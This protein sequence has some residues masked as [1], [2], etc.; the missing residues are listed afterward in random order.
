MNIIFVNFELCVN[1]EG[2]KIAQNW[3]NIFIV[4]NQQAV[5]WYVAFNC[6]KSTD[7]EIGYKITRH[8]LV[9]D[10]QEVS[11]RSASAFA[12]DNVIILGLGFE[13]LAGWIEVL[14]LDG[15]RHFAEIRP[16]GF[17]SVVLHPLP[18]G[19]VLVRQHRH[20]PEQHEQQIE[21]DQLAGV[22]AEICI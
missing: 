11:Q 13:V 20:V 18:H 2:I 7:R 19:L 6:A 1:F 21:R 4:W 16:V 17:L 14:V 5:D 8:V 15:Q 9:F 22:K 10:R 3:F 12:T